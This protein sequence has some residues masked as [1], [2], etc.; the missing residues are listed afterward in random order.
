MTSRERIESALRHKQPDRTPIFEYVL[1]S[2]RADELLGRHYAAD[3]AHWDEILAEKGWKAAVRQ[4]ALDQLELTLLLGHDMLYVVPN[5][6]PAGI[7]PASGSPAQMQGRGT[8]SGRQGKARPR[9][10][11]RGR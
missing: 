10:I 2:P 1:Q 4:R 7:A 11:C 6:A 9:H 5:P 8:H 3:S